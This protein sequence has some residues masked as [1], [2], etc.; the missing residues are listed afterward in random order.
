VEKNPPPKV[1]PGA[2]ERRLLLPATAAALLLAAGVGLFLVVAAGTA[3]AAGTLIAIDADPYTPGIQNTMTYPEGTDP[4]EI[5][6]VVQNA[7]NIGAFEFQLSFDNVSLEYIGWALGP[8][9]GS[10]GRVVTC[11]QIITENTIRIGCTTTGPPPPDGPSGDGVLVKI[12]FHPKFPGTTC[13]PVMLVETAEI[14]GHPIPTSG[15]SG[16]V[17]IVQ[18]TPTPIP[19]STASPRAT[20]TRAVTRTV[21]PTI[22]RTVLATR[23][24]E[25]TA[26]HSETAVPSASATAQPEET[27][28]STPR[29]VTVTRTAERTTT[30]RSTATPAPCRRSADYWRTH[31]GEWPAKELTLGS[32]VY[33]QDELLSLLVMPAEDDASVVLAR[34]LIVARLESASGAS[35]A[36][37]AD[38]AAADDLLSGTSG[39]LP[40]GVRPSTFYGQGMIWVAASLARSHPDCDGGQSPAGGSPTSVTNVLGGSRPRTGPSGLPSTGAS[41]ALGS[42]AATWVITIMS[43]MIGV[44]LVLLLRKT[45]FDDAEE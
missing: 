35:A 28:T 34:E 30:P 7:T 15:Q 38:I 13:L 24:V 22:T 6:V 8:F 33:S 20:S 39:K 19:T 21:A 4:I 42:E 18:S 25:V 23:T 44:L 45:L 3:F 1:A 26:T 40:Y 37:L 5:D 36:S 17:T 14:F 27:R 9:L 32:L 31:A 29:T 10:T 11:Q 2:S 41:S 12:G 43:L 16:C